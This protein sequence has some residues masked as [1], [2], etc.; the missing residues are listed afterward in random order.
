M[1]PRSRRVVA[2][3]AW[4]RW[5]GS[6]GGGG[7]PPGRPSPTVA[8]IFRVDHATCATRGSAAP[9]ATRATR[10]GSAAG[11]RQPETL[12][13][14]VAASH[15][16]PRPPV[17]FGRGGSERRR[18][19]RDR[20]GQQLSAH[21]IGHRLPDRPLRQRSEMVG[22]RIDQRVA[23]PPGTPPRHRCRAATGHSLTAAQHKLPGHDSSPLRASEAIVAGAS[24]S[25]AARSV[26]ARPGIAGGAKYQRGL[27][28]DTARSG[29]LHPSRRR[30]RSAS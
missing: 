22:H 30:S 18:A 3:A 21:I 11:R 6:R 9:P 10:P 26:R 13:E 1:A 29:Q 23:G 19:L 17:R 5:A 4:G 7:C 12:R 24:P 16:A 28:L 20:Q 2:L 14:H 8:E 15:G 27:P 25:R